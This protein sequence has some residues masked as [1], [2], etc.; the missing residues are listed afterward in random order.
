MTTA[1]KQAFITA[2]CHGFAPAWLVSIAFKALRLKH[3]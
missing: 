3:Q 2:Y 1:I